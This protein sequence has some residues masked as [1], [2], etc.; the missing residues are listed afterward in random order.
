[1]K[2]LAT[3]PLFAT[4]FTVPFVLADNVQL[5]VAAPAAPT[6][7]QTDKPNFVFILSD[8]QDYEMGSLDYIPLLKKYIADEGTLRRAWSQRKLFPIWFTN[9]G[10]NAY[11]TGKFQNGQ[12]KSNY[13]KDPAHALMKGW[14]SADVLLEPYTYNYSQ[15]GMKRDKA[16][17][18]Q[19]NNYTTDLIS[20]KGIKYI[21][22]AHE[23]GKPFFVGIA[24]IAPHVQTWPAGGNATPTPPQR[25]PISAPR[26]SHMFPNVVV[27]PTKNFNPDKTSAGGW[28]QKLP[29]L[30]TRELDRAKKFYRRRLQALQAVDE[31]VEA[32]IQALDD[33]E[34][35]NNTYVIYTTDNGYHIGQH[36]I[37]AGKGCAYETDVHIPFM[38]RGPGV[39]KGVNRTDVVTNH[40]D[41]APTLLTLAGIPLSLH[42]F[43][44]TPMPITKAGKAAHVAHEHVGIEFW[45]EPVFEG[46]GEDLDKSKFKNNTYK[47]LRIMGNGEN[48]FNLGYIVWCNGDHELY[49]M[50]L[51]PYQTD[52]LMPLMSSGNVTITIGGESYSVNKVRDRLDG[53]VQAVR[54]CDNGACDKPW[55]TLHTNGSV[56]TLADAMNTEFDDYYD[57]LAKM[58]YERCYRYY[59][60]AAEGPVQGGTG[61]KISDMG[62]GGGG[63]GV[64]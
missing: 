19:Y 17:F 41:V 32:V 10:Y 31:L 43:D 15:P 3:F 29:K 48:T 8:D 18:Q 26:H 34:L 38:V 7:P 25:L 28:V 47:A 61:I 12:A 60:A 59:N 58:K 1:M 45:G 46:A 35:L 2:P 6:S 4:I 52:N 14:T 36:R 37:P 21:N 22:E 40:V 63:S 5:S 56:S 57:G 64:G 23:A 33:L 27:P 16:D 54:K 9:N 44:G 11:Y 24:P 42:D 55:S 51:D 50:T 62:W 13:G 30:D 49:D 39:D 20:S 53:L